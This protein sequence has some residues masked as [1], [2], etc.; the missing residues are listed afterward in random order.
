VTKCDYDASWYHGSPHELSVLR[1]GSWITQFK[2]IAKAF[3]HK[4]SL[5]SLADDCRTVKHNGTLPGFLYTVAERI[6][7]ADISE[8]P[9]TAHTHWQTQ[10]DLCVHLVTELPLSQPPLLTAKEIADM[11]KTYPE[12]TKGTRFI[13]AEDHRNDDTAKPANPGSQEP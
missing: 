13:D 5:M 1:K 8:L 3:S 10:R 7:P 2:E 12:A 6:G 9:D 4:P 11:R